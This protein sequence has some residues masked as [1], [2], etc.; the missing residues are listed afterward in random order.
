MSI[1]PSFNYT[2]RIDLTV[3]AYVS[4]SVSTT[5]YAFVS[6]SLKDI[7]S[8]STYWPILK[9]V[10]NI[11]LAAGELIPTLSIGGFGIDNTIGSFGANRKFSDVLER[12]TPIEQTVTIYVSEYQTDIDAAT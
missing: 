8:G 12:Y 4:G 9:S 10:G 5:T 6:K 7:S 11:T 1:A 3:A 2:Y